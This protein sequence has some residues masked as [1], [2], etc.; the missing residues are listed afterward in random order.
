MFMLKP[1]YIF[2]AES[3]SHEERGNLRIFTGCCTLYRDKPLTL[4]R[5]S[6]SLDHILSDT[7]L[8]QTSNA[9]HFLGNLLVLVSL[10]GLGM[11]QNAYDWKL[12]TRVR[13]APASISL[14]ATSACPDSMARC[15]GVFP[16]SFCINSYLTNAC[17][18]LPL[19]DTICGIESRL[20]GD[21]LR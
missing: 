5:W 15:N 17:C 1:M 9:L 11:F 20:H 19:T 2:L 21:T 14:H 10:Y 12:L 3:L 16:S 6:T 18:E 8:L 13:S 7:L 4:L